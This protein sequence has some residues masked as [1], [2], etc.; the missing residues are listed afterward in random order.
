MPL[1]RVGRTCLFSSHGKPRHRAVKPILS[2]TPATLQR[3]GELWRG[4]KQP[5]A[6]D[7]LGLLSSGT[8]AGFGP[9]ELNSSEWAG[10]V[11]GS[12]QFGLDG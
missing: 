8:W 11:S 9:L 7:R 4:T 5:F 10:A 1:V 12:K 2:A 6:V 3:R